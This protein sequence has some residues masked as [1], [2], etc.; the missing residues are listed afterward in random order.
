MSGG[1][2][3]SREEGIQNLYNEEERADMRK[4]DQYQLNQ[5]ELSDR[6]RM[7][8]FNADNA[9]LEAALAGKLGRMELI[10]SDEQTNY[11]GKDSLGCY[12]GFGV[13][14]FWEDWEC[15]IA[16]EDVHKTDFKTDDIFKMSFAAAQDGSDDWINVINNI[17][18]RADSLA[19][20]LFPMH[21]GNNPIRGFMVGGGGKTLC[22][23]H[24]IR[25]LKSMSI[26]LMKTGGFTST[27]F[28][29]PKITVYG[30]R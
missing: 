3:Y 15:V 17:E 28:V 7:E 25:H 1:N 5:W 14:K 24:P 20:V 18:V 27:R 2:S 10:Y 9:K 12:F 26:S 11:N 19:V 13:T 8:D 23:D 16:F 22:S 29:D 30:I 4:T 21:N 6:V